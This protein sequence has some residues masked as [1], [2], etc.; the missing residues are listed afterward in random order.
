MHGLGAPD[1]HVHSRPRLAE[2]W[3]SA[4]GLTLRSPSLA[5]RYGQATGNFHQ[6]GRWQRTFYRSFPQRL[7]S[8]CRGIGYEQ[9]YTTTAIRLPYIVQNA[10]YAPHLLCSL[11]SSI[12]PVGGRQQKKSSEI[13]VLETKSKIF[14]SV[15]CQQCDDLII[16]AW[17]FTRSFGPTIFWRTTVSTLDD[18][19]WIIRKR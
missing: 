5:A 18:E 13:T 12:R 2:Y 17:I 16:K 6:M 14:T 19:K 4:W 11:L 9:V 1:Q 8:C 7:Q 10:A 15:I 3:T